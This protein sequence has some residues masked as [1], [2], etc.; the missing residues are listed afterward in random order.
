MCLMSFPV[1]YLQYWELV[2][3][4]TI[5][6]MLSIPLCDSAA[7][8]SLNTNTFIAD[9]CIWADFITDHEIQD[10][11]IKVNKKYEMLMISHCSG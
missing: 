4:L 11:S 2:C 10:K 6:E 5:M 7:E 1:H 9:P 3:D 8:C